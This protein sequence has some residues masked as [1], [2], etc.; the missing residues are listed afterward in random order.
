MKVFYSDAHLAHRPRYYFPEGGQGDRRNWPLDCQ[1][2]SPNF[3]G[4]G[5][6]I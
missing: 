6:R 2:E 3:G 1:P 4:D 5:G